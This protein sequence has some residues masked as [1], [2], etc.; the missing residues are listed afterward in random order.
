MNSSD[1]KPGYVYHIKDSYF[2]VAQD[3]KLM[4]NHESGS[5][6][7]TYLCLKD[8]K[9]GLLWVIPMSNRVEKYQSVIIKRYWASWEMRKD[10]YWRICKQA[11][12][13]FIS[14]YVSD[15]AKI[16]LSHTYNS[17]EPSTRKSTAANDTWQKLS[18]GFA[19]SSAGCK[20]C[21]SRH[22]PIGKADVR[23]TVCRMTGPDQPDNILDRYDISIKK[24]LEPHNGAKI[25]HV[26]QFTIR[27]IGNY[28]V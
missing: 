25:C 9:T 27:R 18:R 4:R 7:P 22:R 11:K 3:D 12:C 5:Y 17:A 16:F 24:N 23:R 20:S 19:S 13:F 14:K 1:I 6:R 28:E 2:E 15:I 10:L 21:F 26:S 8:E